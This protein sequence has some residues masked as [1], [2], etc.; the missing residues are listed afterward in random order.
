MTGY[1]KTYIRELGGFI[2]LLEGKHP[3]TRFSGGASLMAAK[4]AT[5]KAEIAAM[6]SRGF[7]QES[8]AVQAAQDLLALMEG[9]D[10][11]R[12]R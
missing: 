3:V 12:T 5:I 9:R 10:D 4:C 1:R 2:A 11:P 7:A 8:A 6:T